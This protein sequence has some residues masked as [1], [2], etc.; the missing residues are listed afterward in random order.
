MRCSSNAST[1]DI[2]W[3]FCSLVVPL[4]LMP[5]IFKISCSIVAYVFVFLTCYHFPSYQGEAQSI[6]RFLQVGLIIY[7][8]N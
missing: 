5:L 7:A 6:E 2:S 1:F 3:V 4:L 8:R